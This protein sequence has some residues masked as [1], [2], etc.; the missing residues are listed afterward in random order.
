MSVGYQYLVDQVRE[1]TM[2]EMGDVYEETQRQAAADLEQAR[3]ELRVLE[4][5]R[6]PRV[7]L[8]WRRLSRRCPRP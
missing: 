5:E 6:A 3:E 7:R 1:Q 2:R 4:Q 8:I